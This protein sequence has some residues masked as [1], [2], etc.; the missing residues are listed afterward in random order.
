V[1]TISCRVTDR[2]RGDRA[3]GTF[4]A[5]PGCVPRIGEQLLFASQYDPP[6]TTPVCWQVVAVMWHVGSVGG[7]VLSDCELLVQPTP[8]PFWPGGEPWWPRD[9]DAEGGT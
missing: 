5:A 4:E 9:E 1:E 8:G 2:S 7:F 3:V 6:G